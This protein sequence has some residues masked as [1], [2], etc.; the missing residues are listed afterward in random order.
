MKTSAPTFADLWHARR[1]L[2][3][4]LAPTPLVEHPVLSSRLG[5]D[6][7]VK[8][9]NV[10]PLGAFKIRGGLNLLA[11]LDDR[12]RARGL[13]SATRGNHGQSLAHAC[14]LYGVECALFVPEGNNPDKNAAMQ[15]LGARVVVGGRDFDEAWELASRHAERS[16]AHLVHP[17]R[18]PALV[19]GVGTLA[20]EIVEQAG[21]PLDAVIVPVG[22]GSCIAGAALALGELSPSTRIIGV[23][24]AH[25]P[26]MHHAWRSGESTPVAVRPTL[27]DGLAVRVPVPLT[28]EI[29]RARVDEMVLVDETE[30]ASAV[31]CYLETLHQLAEGAGA[32]ALAGAFALTPALR[33]ARVAVVLS[34]GNIDAATLHSV[35]STGA[36]G[37]APTSGIRA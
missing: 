33:G 10:Q 14:A 2:R 16:G 18:E 29:M 26:A 11:S 22:V 36:R 19:A 28:L 4:H 35:M 32:A 3:R 13:C 37:H 5:F 31:R 24:A 6:A 7:L 30:I 20:I 25:A 8:L 1:V 34:G 23:Q 12:Q 27:A 15:A 21:H 9:E 17:G